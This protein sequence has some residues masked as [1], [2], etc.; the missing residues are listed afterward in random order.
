M[1]EYPEN[2]SHS[3]PIECSQKGEQRSAPAGYFSQNIPRLNILVFEIFPE[4]RDAKKPR[5]NRVC[6]PV[7]RVIPRRESHERTLRL[8][9]DHRT[10]KNN[11]KNDKYG[12][13]KKNAESAHARMTPEYSKKKSVL[14]IEERRQNRRNEC[15][16]EKRLH[17]QKGNDSRRK[18]NEKEKCGIE[19]GGA[20]TYI[21]PHKQR[22]V[23]ILYITIPFS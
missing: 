3:A 18:K 8:A 14:R 1:S 7:N 12:D 10:H 20:H 17:Y 11:R 13:K 21:V 9:H 2:K 22:R 4:I 15:G 16:R 19:V 6:R 23:T 5:F